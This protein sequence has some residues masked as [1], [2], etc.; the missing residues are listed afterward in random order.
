MLFCINLFHG[1]PVALKK[2]LNLS[3]LLPPILCQS[4]NELF[5]VLCALFCFQVITQTLVFGIFF[6]STLSMANPPHSLC[7]SLDFFLWKVLIRCFSL[8]KHIPCFPITLWHIS[9]LVLI[10]LYCYFVFSLLDLKLYKG[11]NLFFF[12]TLLYLQHLEIILLTS[13]TKLI[14]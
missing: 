9:I 10:T 7:P 13:G 5:S 1:Y 2:A 4:Y 12:S 8:C 14:C 6:L 11:R 3:P